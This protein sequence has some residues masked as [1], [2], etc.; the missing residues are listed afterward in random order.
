MEE[1]EKYRRARYEAF[2]GLYPD[3][4][5]YLRSYHNAFKALV[6]NLDDRRAN[7]D[8]IAFPLLFLAR[9]CME[10][11]FKANIRYFQKYSRIS[12]HTRSKS[13]DL[14]LLFSAF[15]LHM[16]NTIEKLEAEFGSKVNPEDI[17][18]FNEYCQE[19]EI[20]N[21]QFHLLDKGSYSFR[22]PVDNDGKPVFEPD[23]TI[24]IVDVINLF[25]KTMTLLY[26]TSDVFSKYT[27]YSDSIQQMYEDEM[28]SAYEDEMRNQMP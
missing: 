3:F 27:D 16:N 5:S 10:L 18:S 25:N 8:S 1:T 28:R 17:R 7:V 26:H 21:D 15:K 9:H 24:N 14:K 11:G 12:D 19:V 6:Q 20:L 13:H 2:I 23:E 22:Y 4:W